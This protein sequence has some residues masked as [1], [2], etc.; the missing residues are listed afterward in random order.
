MH[1]IRWRKLKL[2]WIDYVNIWMDYGLFSL[3]I[4]IHERFSLAYLIPILMFS[5][6]SRFF[7][8]STCSISTKNMKPNGNISTEWA[9]VL[10]FVWEEI[11][12]YREVICF[13]INNLPFRKLFSNF[14]GNR[15]NS[16][17]ATVYETTMPKKY[18]N[19]WKRC[20]LVW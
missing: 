3:Y 20:S 11:L 17:T 6:L 9:K 14:K 7:Y 10:S 12:F 18:F 8:C 15:L 5:L 2:I 1:Q 4:Y 19:S 13:L 16:A